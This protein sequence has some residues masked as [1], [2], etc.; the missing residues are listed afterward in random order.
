MLTKYEEDNLHYYAEADANAWVINDQ[1]TY[2]F[3][4]E[5]S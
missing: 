4:S 3:A 2:N 5:C 1:N